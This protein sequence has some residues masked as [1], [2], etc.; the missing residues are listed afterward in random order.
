MTTQF[1]CPDKPKELI[2]IKD[3]ATCRKRKTCSTLD[4][5]LNFEKKNK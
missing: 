3:C 1:Q 2:T 5:E 4:Y